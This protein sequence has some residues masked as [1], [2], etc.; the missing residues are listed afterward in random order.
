[1]T[2][3]TMTVG[4]SAPGALIGLTAGLGGWLIISRLPWRRVPTLDQRLAPYLRGVR[5]GRPASEPNSQRAPLDLVERLLGPFMTDAVRWAER[6]SGGA[7]TVRRRLDQLGGRR[8]VEQFRA[9]QVLC[10]VLGASTGAA[11]GGLTVIG[12]GLSVVP[13]LGLVV[14]GT[15]L[16][17]LGRDLWLSRQVRRRERRILAEFP[18]VAELLALAVGAGEGPVGALER[19]ARTCRGELSAELRRT[20]ADAR[21]GMSLIDA[22]A[23]LANRTTLP[24]LARFVDGVAVAVDRGTPLADVLRAQAQDVRE[25]TRRRL[26]EAGGR[27][28]IGMMVPVVFLVLPITVL[29]AVY[30]GLVVLDLDL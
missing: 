7:G 17:V 22:L 27:R 1:M 30:P 8:S 9:E 24:G 6:I 13:V 16:G 4:L 12:R 20:V 29:F 28:E 23:G 11:I 21:T 25:L 19:V 15:L 3:A 14:V 18:A 5:P 26:M 10:G 2:A